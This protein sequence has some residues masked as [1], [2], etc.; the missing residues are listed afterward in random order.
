MCTI[1]K[2]SSFY[3]TVLFT[4]LFVLLLI[5]GSSC[6]NKLQKITTHKKIQPKKITKKESKKLTVKR[7]KRSKISNLF[8]SQ[9]KQNKTSCPDRNSQKYKEPGELQKS[10]KRLKGRDED[11]S[12]RFRLGVEVINFDIVY[13]EESKLDIPSFKQFKNNMTDFTADGKLEFE[14]I[15]AKIKMYLGENTNGKGVTLEIF[16]SASQIP[17]SFDP[18]LANNN[19]NEDGSSIKGK[20]NIDN[21]KELARERALELA[22]KIKSVFINIRIETP[23]LEEITIGET[24]WNKEVQA[25]LDKAYLAGNKKEMKRIFEPFQKEQ[26]VKVKSKET[27]IKTI[28]PN[29]IRMY[30]L[31]ATPRIVIDGDPVKSRFVISKNTYLQLNEGRKGFDHAEKRDH[32]FKKK[33]LHTMQK[34]INN[35]K[36]WY[37]I[38]GHKEKHLLHYSEEYK[39]ILESH[40]IKIVDKR[41]YDILEKILTKIELKEKR[42]K[43]VLKN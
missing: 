37:L 39:R 25:H 42:F 15:I 9:E 32:F 22:E 10:K 4:A 11:E 20:T 43:Y 6:H 18:S 3:I 41:D 26:F 34:I 27:F 31:I 1:M 19:I 5:S 33:G 36:R 30:T 7:K 17:T 38:H 13:V 24:P 28:Q 12:A 29:S 2:R 23:S 16:G 40:R 21:N 35:E 8:T 14:N